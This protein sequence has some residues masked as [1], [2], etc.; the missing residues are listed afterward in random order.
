MLRLAFIFCV[1]L[2]LSGCGVAAM[3]QSRTDMINAKHEYEACLK[4]NPNNPDK[5]EALRRAFKADLETYEAT[6]NGLR[7]GGVISIEK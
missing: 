6:R 7:P 3:Q 2:F 5:C 4:A 1:A